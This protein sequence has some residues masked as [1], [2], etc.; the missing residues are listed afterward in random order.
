MVLNLSN[1][2]RRI[3]YICPRCGFRADA[4]VYMFRCPRCGSPLNVE[5]DAKKPRELSR[6]ELLRTL[7]IKEPLTLGEGLTP[8]VERGGVYYKLE[9]LNPTGSFKDRGWAFTLSVL[10]KGLTLV[11]DSS[12]NAGMSLSAYAA[13][14]GFK[15]RIYV[16]KTASEAKRR[17]MRL[18]GATVIDAPSRADASSLAM[19]Y[20]DGVY[21]GHSW[22][23][24]FIHGVKLIAYE[25]ALEL[26]NVDNVIAPLGNGTLTLGLYVGFRELRE[27]KVIKDIPRIIAVEASGY[28]WAYAKI[29]NTVPMGSSTLPEGIMVPRP[30]RLDQI[31]DAIR[32]SGGD[33]VVAS[34]DDVARGIR[35]GLRLGFLIEPTS[36]VVFKALSELRP[37]GRTVV[38]LTGSGLKSTLDL[39]RLVVGE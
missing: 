19:S 10:N 39:Y 25:I 28:E 30:P 11:E 9:Y 16:P 6:A 15:A 5:Y 37:N 36:A 24:F 7:P 2:D 32:E 27:L 38:I 18:F 17:A 13:S 20:R 22:N 31:V 14:A 34:D 29:H 3:E 4:T 33:V 26:G 21:V 23:P 35:E 8:I 12:G 1:M